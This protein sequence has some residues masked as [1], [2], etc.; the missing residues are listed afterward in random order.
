MIWVTTQKGRKMPIDAEPVGKGK[1]LLNPDDM[2]VAF[3]PESDPYTGER[4]SSH[5][6]TC[7]DREKFRDKPNP[8][9]AKE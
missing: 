4:Y 7:P 1:F 3:I 2:T 8:G 9:E 5:F 6:E